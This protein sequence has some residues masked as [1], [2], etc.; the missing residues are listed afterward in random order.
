MIAQVQIKIGSTW[1]DLS[2]DVVGESVK[3]S[4]GIAGAAPGDRIA[5]PGT[6]QFDLDNSDGPGTPSGVPG[7]HVRGFYT[8][9]HPDCMVGF[10][11]GAE[12]RL[13]LVDP[14]LGSRVRWIG[15]VETATPKPGV[16]DPRTVVSCVDW[17]EEAARAKLKGIAVQ[18]SIQSDALFSLLVASMDR[19]PPDGV[20]SG[21]GSD[22]YPY[23]L[24]NTQDESSRIL[25]ELQKIAMSEIGLVYVTAGQ[26]VFEGRKMRG[27]AGS[28][29]FAYDADRIKDAVIEYARDSILNRVQVSIHPRRV[30]PA[31]TAVLFNLGSSQQIMRMTALVLDCP[32]RDPNQQAQ[33]VGGMDLVT[34]A[35]TTDY[36][37]N[38]QAD[39]LGTNLSSQLTV[40]YVGTP[41]GNT[42]T[43]RAYNNGP[44][45]GYLIMLKL[46]G[47]GL[48][49]F[50][51]VLS[52]LQDDDSIAAYGENPLPYDM[53]Y[54]SSPANAVD[55]A[56]FLLARNKDSV[57]RC[58]SLTFNAE[59]DDDARYQGFYADVSD[60]VSVTLPEAGLDAVQ[61]FI[62][63]ISLDI[64]ISGPMTVTFMLS[65]PV[66][67]SQFWLLG[68]AGRSEL[69][70]TTVLGYGLFAAGWILGTSTLD[71]DTF[72]N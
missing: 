16:E 43:V 18:T 33:R 42:A 4:W 40:T 51:P 34:P 63:G 47:R 65:L 6:L 7:D 2:L 14:L 68:V 29:R 55:T 22:I 17:M 24:D 23:A 30:D 38:S 41:G 67:T 52:D 39:G 21:T 54:Q 19:Q 20:R 56:Q 72:L 62:N 59:W 26:L 32:Y 28:V 5:D 64:P 45:D 13:V 25:S 27:S 48:Y 31:A 44:L 69:D 53:P 49:D 58:S 37:F 35:I 70:F 15:T 11:I 12:V 46:R 71:D 36:L 3:A 9:K 10:E 61:Y 66:D 57:V 60:R 1:T 50:E 8:P